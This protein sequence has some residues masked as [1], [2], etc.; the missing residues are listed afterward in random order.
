MLLTASLLLLSTA[1][2]QAAPDIVHPH[3]LSCAGRIVE[4]GGQRNGQGELERGRG[5][6]PILRGA[7]AGADGADTGRHLR[8]EAVRKIDEIRASHWWKKAKPLIHIHCG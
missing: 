8:P 7:E 3:R 5:H 2:P 4:Q 1:A 6:L